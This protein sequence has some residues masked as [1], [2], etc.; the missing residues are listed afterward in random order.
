MSGISRRDFLAAGAAAAVHAAA[1]PSPP[2]L[3]R[4]IKGV[5]WLW[6]GG[7]MSQI[8]TWDPKPGHKNGGEFKA[9][10]TA[11]PGLQLSQY[12][13][14]CASQMKHVALIRSMSTHEGSHARGTYLM[15][16]GRPVSLPYEVPSIGTILA[17]ELGAKGL[18]LPCHIAIDPPPIPRASPFGPEFLPV[19]LNNADDPIP[20]VR[21]AY[22]SPREAARRALLRDED[23]EWLMGRQQE[24]TDRLRVSALESDLLANSPLLDA[25]DWRAEPR[26]LRAAY[27]DRFGINCLLARRLVQAGCAFVEIGMGGWDMRGDTFWS[28][29]R[30]LPALDAGLGTLIWD[31]AERDLLK[32][33]LVVC[34]SEFGRTPLINAGKGRDHHADGFSVV[35]AGGFLK[36]GRVYGDTG[37]DGASCRQP[38]SAADLAATILQACGVDRTKSYDAGGRILRYVEGGTP[39]AELF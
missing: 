32:D 37:P 4:K 31:L 16:T 33:V 2:A 17:F 23:R 28:L 18:P 26:E 30:M 6:M 5:I 15:H 27:G 21:E 35:L 19:R 22:G 8:D 11:V 39:I 25:F 7:G 24:E 1:P 29:K 34:A 13:P 36:R 14:V 3:P 12:L 9:I 20:N 38:V 10:D